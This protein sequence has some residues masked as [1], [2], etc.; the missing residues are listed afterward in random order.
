M[1][2]LKQLFKVV[3]GKLHWRID[4]KHSA[5]TGEECNVDGTVLKATDILAQIGPKLSTGIDK[6]PSGQFR[7]RCMLSGKR[8]TI[9]HFDTETEAANAIRRR[10]DA[11]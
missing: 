9:G 3:N 8:I 4:A 7:A 6:R 1:T 10:Q 11:A 2:R 5:P